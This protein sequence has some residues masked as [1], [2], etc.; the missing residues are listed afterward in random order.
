MSRLKRAIVNVTILVATLAIFLGVMEAGL[1]VTGA[2][3][4]FMYQ[5]D[6]ELGATFIP[7]KQGWHV[8]RTNGHRQ[9]IEINR[10]GFRDRNWPEAK[11]P[12]SYRI[13]LLGDSY[14][15]GLEVDLADRL[16]EQVQHILNRQTQ[17]RRVEILNFGVVGFGTA[18]ALET[19]R[20]R[21]AQFQPDVALLFFYTGNDLVNNSPELDP[22]P[23]KLYY[24]LGADGQLIRRPFTVSDNAVKQWLRH[25][26]KAFSFIRD[27]VKKIESLN[28][29]LA[30][31]GLIQP[32]VGASARA[33]EPTRDARLN[34][35]RYA[36]QFVTPPPAITRAWQVTEALVREMQ[37]EA[38]NRAMDLK[39]V[40]V[41][42]E[43]EIAGTLPKDVTEPLDMERMLKQ[44]E[45]I[46]G[47]LS[48]DCLNL[49]HAF[50]EPGVRREAAFFARD[51]H[52]TEYGHRIAATAIAKWLQGTASE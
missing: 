13:A 8:L 32:T 40:I 34:T 23:N 6:Q 51:G 44:M 22:E 41:P 29:G 9:R 36:Q 4:D 7:N 33:V 46:C 20:H 37:R 47:N 35:L 2:Q 49:V 1:R 30:I 42:A 5:L 19:L 26:S 14:V 12:G 15:A 45:R 11:E 39:V 25:H 3:P 50:R 18:S 16:G 28:R 48:L 52:W 24:V 17:D 10:F 43:D 31:G 27:R 21:A 38:R